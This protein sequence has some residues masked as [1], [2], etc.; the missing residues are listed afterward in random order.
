MVHQEHEG[1]E[2]GQLVS[3]QHQGVAVAQP[4]RQASRQ[5][6]AQSKRGTD[7]A[8]HQV[9]VRLRHQPAENRVIQRKAG[10][11][12][13]AQGSEA[14]VGDFPGTAGAQAGSD[15]ASDHLSIMAVC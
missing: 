9:F 8:R 6:A 2:E 11:S 1:A 10:D 13:P 14:Q 4:R 12:E 3:H 15:K 5:Q 7:G